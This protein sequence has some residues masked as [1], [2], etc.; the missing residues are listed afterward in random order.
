MAHPMVASTMVQI[1]RTDVR[2][3]GLGVGGTPFGDMY[4]EV[5]DATAVATVRAAFAAG[6]RYFDTAPLYGV[7][8]AERR[9]G[10]GIAGLPRDEITISTKIG[11]ILQDADGTV[12][13]TF[14]YTPHAVVASLESSLG[15]LG[16]DRVD[17]V[18][19]HDPDDHLDEV[20]ATTLPLLQEMKAAGRI[21]AVSAGMNHAG[22][23]ARFVEAGLVDCVMVAGRW[24][25]LDQSAIHELLPAATAQG[26]SVIAAGVFNS[27]VLAD[28][29]GPHAH[30]FYARTPADVLA[31]VRRISDVCRGHGV[32]LRAAA[33]QFPL[34]HPAVATVCI[35]CRSPQEVADNVAGLAEAVP[36]ELWIALAEAGLLAPDAVPADGR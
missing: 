23:L 26:A 4:A 35:G 2:V 6:V 31:K 19:V 8:R 13:P 7:G 25:L 1:G 21:G 29:D 10:L 22:P 34:T 20:I 24:T 12:A 36:A 17:I 33:L 14:E 9:L 5:P 27:G 18:H 32:S 30:Y 16:L 15:R 28:P 11:R 3:S